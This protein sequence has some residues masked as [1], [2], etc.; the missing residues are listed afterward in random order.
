MK[1]TNASTHTIP[2]GWR[3]TT[4]G[5]AM[6][7][8]GG[9]TPRTTEPTY[10]DGNIPWLSVAD[11]NN[12]SRWVSE[13][14]KTITETGVSESATQVLRAGD[15]VLSARGTVGALAQLK[16]PMAFN[17]SCYGIRGIEGVSEINFLFYK[18]RNELRSLQK[19]VHG[20]VFDTITRETFDNICT[21]LPPLPEQKSIAAVLS[22]LDNK[23]ELLREQNK[24]L[25]ATAQALFKHWFVDFEFPNADGKPYRSSGG[26]MVD[27]ELGEIPEGWGV[28]TI[29]DITEV[30]TKGTTPTTAGGGFTE[31]GI[32]FIKAETL[33]DNNGFDF[34]K[35]SFID[36]K[37]NDLLKRSVIK[38]G[39][40]LYTIAGTIGRFAVATEQV[41]PANTNQAVAIIRPSSNISPYFFVSTFGLLSIKQALTEGVLEAVQANLSL[42]NIKA[43]SVIVP[44]D[45]GMSIFLTHIEPLFRKCEESTSQIQ[46]LA[47]TR[48]I[49]LPQL[50][51]GDVRVTI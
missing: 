18:L 2:D 25:E 3:E 28:H 40:I 19:N 24:T 30:V 45:F 15:L 51:R 42:G 43:L 5:D 50:M 4:L 27:S 1:M 36:E 48:D 17:Q 11:F 22:S 31:K 33:T 35:M 20:A 8:L 38:D 13:T 39:D 37:T 26:K 9:G 21:Y 47:K 14:E 23:I 44:D 16:K 49:L 34:S 10:W 6:I 12:S 46:S 41:L 29:E 7:L 32:N